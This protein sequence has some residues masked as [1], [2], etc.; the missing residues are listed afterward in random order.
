MCNVWVLSPAQRQNHNLTQVDRRCARARRAQSKEQSV[1]LN[2]VICDRSA[3]NLPGD[4]EKRNPSGTL[5][6]EKHLVFECPELQC[7]RS[8]GLTCLRGHRQCWLSCGKDDLIGVA[9]FVKH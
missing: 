5:G 2:I 9:K 4:V 8:S 3:L 1:N 6:D 7:F